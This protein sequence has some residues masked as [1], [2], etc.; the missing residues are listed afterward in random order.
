[1]ASSTDRGDQPAAP[2]L[3]R[4]QADT[5]VTPKP[6][7][8][9]FSKEM[10]TGFPALRQE[11]LSRLTGRSGYQSDISEEEQDPRMPRTPPET[12]LKRPRYR[13]VNRRATLTE[14]FVEV[15]GQEEVWMHLKDD[16][17]NPP[18]D[19]TVK[20]ATEFLASVTDRPQEVYDALIRFLD[21]HRALAQL[22]ET[23][24][25]DIDTL[26][27]DL[28][29]E[30]KL[31]RAQQDTIKDNEAELQG[32][33]ARADR[34]KEARDS[35]RSRRQE[36]ESTNQVLREDNQSLVKTKGTLERKIASLE[37]DNRSQ[38]AR[39][40]VL[41]DP[42]TSGSDRGQN[43]RP[44]YGDDRRRPA[45][46]DPYR[47]SNRGQRGQEQEYIRDYAQRER[48]GTREEAN[49]RSDRHHHDENCHHR[50]TDRPGEDNRGH[51]RDRSP[52]DR[53]VDKDR[54]YSDGAPSK[55][56][57]P[58]YKEV[59]YFSGDRT[60][61]RKWKIHLQTYIRICAWQFPTTQHKID[62]T[63]DHLDGDAYS[64]IES[65][66]D[67][68]SSDPYRTLDEM[69]RD[70]E[71]LY[72]EKNKVAKAEAKLKD[73]NFRMGVLDRNETFEQLVA[74][75]N[76]T[77]APLNMDDAAKIRHLKWAMSSKL[78]HKAA[79][80]S[81]IKND[82]YAFVEGVR[83]INDWVEDIPADSAHR[84]RETGNRS[85]QEAPRDTTGYAP[86]TYRKEAPPERTTK[87]GGHSITRF[88]PYIR[89]KILKEGRCFKCLGKGH[90]PTEDNAPCKHQPIVG[91]DEAIIKL[92]AMGIAWDGVDGEDYSEEETPAGV[93]TEAGYRSEN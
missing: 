80:L 24:T 35:Q 66:A 33:Q 20:N 53:M 25:G 85:R 50:Q 92:A 57:R 5:F 83:D 10:A 48:R 22:Y 74:R 45:F 9:S 38:R 76:A 15:E 62:F 2:N 69:L 3:G 42:D 51:R 49:D 75:F 59:P 87:I 41:S 27:G 40:G 61:F 88:P 60:K 64:N 68:E 32:A 28:E 39:L 93:D 73:P 16:R 77:I 89:Q 78:Q 13:D 46:S 91:K 7:I 65:R 12:I 21:E 17:T 79:H 14:K 43:R 11:A 37:K 67:P 6:N 36:F 81:S 71:L 84:P 72:G 44:R 54:W 26:N 63:R 30:R 23:A 82:Y 55:E 58:K 31:T 52:N 19:L 4:G 56:P 29:A 90:R 1:M 70:L 86:R 34:Y 8:P 47:D 18:M